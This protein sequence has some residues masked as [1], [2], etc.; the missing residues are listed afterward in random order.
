MRTVVQLSTTNALS[1]MCVVKI[2]I[3]QRAKPGKVCIEKQCRPGVRAQR[4]KTMQGR[5]SWRSFILMSG[6]SPLREPVMNFAPLSYA[7]L[8]G[9]SSVYF[10]IFLWWREFTSQ[11]YFC[12]MALPSS[13]FLRLVIYMGQAHEERSGGHPSGI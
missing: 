1:L 6:F 7:V 12:F 8:C 11:Q 10:E 5:D 4:Q 9:C 3:A 2:G 13:T